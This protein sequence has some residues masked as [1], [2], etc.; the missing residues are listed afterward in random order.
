M[1]DVKLSIFGTALAS[2]RDG[3]AALYSMPT[4]TGFIF[5]AIFV[6]VATDEAL[7]L[8]ATPETMLQTLFLRLAVAVAI[9]GFALTP[10]AIAI[11]RHV[12]LGET[13]ERYVLNLKNPR[14]RMFVAYSA[15]FNLLVLVPMMITEIVTDSYIVG[16]VIALSLVACA[17][18]LATS[19]LFP[20]IAVDAPGASV[21][22]ALQDIHFFRALLISIVAFLPILGTTGVLIEIWLGE[23]P[24]KFTS[25][26]IFYV[27]FLAAVS[28]VT[29][30]AFT[31]MFS[32]LYR[33]WAIRLT[34]L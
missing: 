15:I 10:A 22:N 8:A 2:W 20:A 4:M 30:A 13:A 12:L 6:D 31:A 5:A 29:F 24:S 27:V 7:L 34:G 9:Y 17:I 19:I 25:D 28:S 21:R 18:Y 32:H 33:A 16:A 14:F 26:W 1:T 23:I 11:H 3:L